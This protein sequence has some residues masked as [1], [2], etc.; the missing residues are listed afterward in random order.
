MRAL[1][2]FVVDNDNLVVTRQPDVAFDSH[3]FVNGSSK[4]LEC[5]LFR[6][7]AR[8]PAVCEDAG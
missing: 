7:H 3:A 4:S 8:K 1:Q 5:V 6:R 2:R